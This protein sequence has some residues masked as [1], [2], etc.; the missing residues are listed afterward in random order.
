[1]EIWEALSTEFF[2]NFSM[3]QCPMLIG[4][5]RRSTEGKGWLSPF[6]YQ[7]TILQQ[8]NTLARTQVE[9]SGERLLNEL[10]IF[11]E[12]CD[13]NEKVLVSH[14]LFLR[15]RKIDFYFRH[16]ISFKPLIFLG[17]SFLE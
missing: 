16:L 17:K 14:L 5:M 2:V 1:M 12:Q 15:F 13:E 8:G 3:E 9:S 7:C 10:I 6:D 11:K 4:I